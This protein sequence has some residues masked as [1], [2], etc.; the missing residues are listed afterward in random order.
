MAEIQK[1]AG[2]LRVSTGPLQIGNDWPGVFIRGDDTNLVV[3]RLRAYQKLLL[4][5]PL[6]DELLRDS[7]ITAIDRDLA[8]LE[9]F[10]V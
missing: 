3:G 1:I 10:W 5:E 8:R 4:G 2:T 6:P 9:G 7:M